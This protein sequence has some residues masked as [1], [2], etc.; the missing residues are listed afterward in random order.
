MA[1]QVDLM[2][3]HTASE[4]WKPDIRETAVGGRENN[5]RYNVA[6]AAVANTPTAIQLPFSTAPRL[7]FMKNLGPSGEGILV[8]RDENIVYPFLLL[9]PREFAVFPM[10]DTSAPPTFYARSVG[11]VSQMLL[12]SIWDGW[13]V[14]SES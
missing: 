11:T 2:V 12:I 3:M 6:T 10:P 1:I 5:I 7:V 9:R 8:A 4:P 13:A 14:E